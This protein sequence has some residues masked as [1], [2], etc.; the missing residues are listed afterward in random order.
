MKLSERE[1][2]K[3]IVEKL[4]ERFKK[5]KNARP[6]SRA[7][8][9]YFLKEF[10][11]S[12]THNSNAIEGNTYTFDETRMLIE[13]GI[14]AGSRSLRES[15]DIIGFKQAVDFMYAAAKDRV[16]P[17]EDFIKKIHSFVLRGDDEAGKYREIQ[18][19]VGSLTRVVFR[20]CSPDKIAE[21]MCDYVKTLK[22]DFLIVDSETKK[23]NIDW[24]KIFNILAE[25]HIRFERIH[26]FIDGNGRTGRLILSYQATFAGL[27]PVDIR[28]EDSERYFAAFKAYEKKSE[29]SL[30]AESKTEKLALL[31]AER[32]LAAFDIWLDV[33]SQKI[34]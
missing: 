32:E 24:L 19:Y 20:P 31:L 13:R 8:S 7:E 12:F 5:I 25:D 18:N 21:N 16:L 15:E 23:D 28:Y 9:D 33:F 4:D 2:F 1:K 30:R 11:V 27:L 10:A 34:S 3:I 17:D 22:E 26:P 6:L 29:Y 14:V